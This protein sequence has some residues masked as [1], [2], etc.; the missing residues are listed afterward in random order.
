MQYSGLNKID[1]LLGTTPGIYQASN[2]IVSYSFAVPAI[3]GVSSAAALN[4]SQQSA[5][6]SLLAYVGSITGVNFVEGAAGA[7]S[8][9]NFCVGDISGNA[10][11][12]CEFNG[13]TSFDIAIDTVSFP[14]L[15]NFA[16][17]TDAYQILLHE[18]GHALGLDHSFDG[19]YS[20]PA[21]QDNTS[22]TL[23]S[24]N[25]SFGARSAFA[26]YDLLALG[27]I[28]GS[29]GVGG[30]HG[31]GGSSGPSI[32][33]EAYP[34]V[35]HTISAGGAAA[36]SEAT[37]QFSFT[38]SRTGELSVATTV[39][40]AVTGT[41]NAT[42]FGGALPSGV[43][44]FAAGETT[45]TVTFSASSDETIEP[46][47]TVIVTLGARTGQGAVLGDAKSVTYTLTD[48][49][50]PPAISISSYAHVV[51]G[52]TG[53]AEIVFSISRTGNIGKASEVSWSFLAGTTTAADFAGGVLPKGGTITFAPGQASYHQSIPVA[54][55][56]AIEADE[57]FVVN[58]AA[59]S[60]GTVSN[61]QATGVIRS[62]DVDNTF[63]VAAKAASVTEGHTG[64]QVVEF[65]V[66][67]SGVATAPA[68]VNWQR[69]GSVGADDT[70]S[71]SS[72][73]LS[74]AAGEASKTIR[75]DL[76]GD[77]LIEN[78]ELLTVY[79]LDVSGLGAGLGQTTEAATTV[80]SDDP[81]G[82]VSTSVGTASV[83]EG[84][85]GAQLTHTFTLVRTGDLNQ[86][87]AMP[88]TVGG[89]VDAADFANGRLPTG[90]AQFAA[91]QAST[92]V[93]I[94]T[95]GDTLFEAD[96]TLV[97][98]LAEG[99]VVKPD[100]T[101]GQATAT[102][103]NDDVA[104]EFRV[105]ANSG[106]VVEGSTLGVKTSVRF[107]IVRVGD[108]TVGASVGWKVAGTGSAPVDAADFGT[109]LPSGTVKF[110]PGETSKSIFVTV[111]QD[112]LAEADEA[113]VLQ[114]QNAIG[115][116]ISTTQGS[117]TVVI[118]SDD[119]L[120]QLAL[121]ATPL[122]VVEGNSGARTVTFEVTRSGDLGG[123]SSAQWAIKGAATDGSTQ[124]ANTADFAAGQ[125]LAGTVS[126]A[127]GETR[128]SITVLVQG[129]T[130]VEPNEAFTITL[131]G[132]SNAAI[133]AGKGAVTMVVKNDD[134][135]VRHVSGTA[136]ANDKIVL[137]GLLAD[138]TLGYDAATDAVQLVDGHAGRDGQVN[139]KLVEV[140]QFGDQAIQVVPNFA[141]KV[142]VQLGHAAYGAQGLDQAIYGLGML[143]LGDAGVPAFG[144][145][146][147]ETFFGSMS[148]QQMAA[149]VL[150][151]LQVTPAA[152]GGPNGQ[153]NFAATQELLSSMFTG[154]AVVRGEALL[155][156]VQALGSFEGDA[157]YGAVAAA[158]NDTVAAEWVAE[159][160]AHPATVVGIPS[161][162][163]EVVLG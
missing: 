123:A 9:I 11:G 92:T 87:G 71:A 135:A 106:S 53:A 49:D 130:L 90:T 15:S 82:A 85:A 155:T 109:A 149:Q 118:V 127:A 101:K 84:N 114:L 108:S 67:R 7:G 26:E 111:L 156:V 30:V 78:D 89:T 22:Y 81:K 35:T 63:T 47:E 105:T 134:L 14:D 146:V 117:A 151:N 48:D 112:R 157:T 144:T 23:M 42:D 137:Q 50:A 77:R 126:F 107:E 120:P 25:W 61:G 140:V 58:I 163:V 13:G 3:S 38:V 115:A 70:S 17:G 139:L 99:D 45:K 64:T 97:L 113:L 2:N 104:N 29:D 75:F 73:S 83:K 69:G 150:A 60:F 161:P 39:A 138:Y 158:Y 129:D 102:L 31:I 96:E 76:K 110:S 152:L 33:A 34:P 88:W 142:L 160:A 147:A 46:D 72:G 143:Y 52:N 59:Q 43:V 116:D 62:D 5:V 41:A 51:E 125:A 91:G 24:Y 94:V 103:V 68:T 98:T 55:D 8:T 1:A 27:W 66:T 119:P 148:A 20:L 28:Y 100:A 40:W 95:K 86:A 32:P 19:P 141:E 93:T 133:A 65:I 4:A 124:G 79:L 80:V 145:L 136:A 44:S 56:A 36:V 37:G 121:S 74:F 6:A 128:K 21:G 122:E 12:R 153:Q 154:S 54:G 10:N 18:V 131:D 162:L 159:F 132:A 57:E 16:S